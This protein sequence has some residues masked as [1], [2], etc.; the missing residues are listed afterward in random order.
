MPANR[1]AQ[2]EALLSDS[3][4]AVIATLCASVPM[5]LGAWPDCPAIARPFLVVAT[6]RLAERI[7]A[8]QGCTLTIAR[9]LAA[10]RLGVDAGTIARLRRR[11][12]SQVYRTM[13]VRPAA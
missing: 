4:L 10:A 5:P 8:E 1:R 3:E 2:L 13:A 11:W 12:R 7:R 6:E 9:S